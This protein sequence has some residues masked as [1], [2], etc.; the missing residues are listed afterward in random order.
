MAY[1]QNTCFLPNTARPYACGTIATPQINGQNVALRSAYVNIIMVVKSA[2]GQPKYIRVGNKSSPW[3]N[4]G[5]FIQNFKFGGENT[6]GGS[7]TIYDGTGNDLSTFLNALYEDSCTTN[8]NTIL[9][10]FGY[11]FQGINNQ[12]IMHGASSF[13][14]DSYKG[15]KLRDQPPPRLNKT[16]AQLL[17]GE[18]IPSIN[19]L[20][21]VVSKIDVKPN[22]GGWE[23]TV[24]LSTLID[25]KSMRK[26]LSRAYGSSSG[27]LSLKKAANQAIKDGCGGD[28]SAGAVYF[29]KQGPDG[30][31][32]DLEFSNAEGGEEGPKNVWDPNRLPCIGAIRNW[33]NSLRTKDG[34]GVTLYTDP[35]IDT[36]NLIVMEA[37]P[38]ICSPP[39]GAY[40][41]GK[42]SGPHKI[43]LVNAGDCSPVI[44][45]E[46]TVQ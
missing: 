8:T 42:K 37:S 15:W 11:I 32:N 9:V 17:G 40:C 34:L 21:F 23:Y 27:L 30:G 2:S 16:P 20:G 46:P 33:L 18:A 7:F 12:P 43:Y 25:K 28:P 29:A 5:A 44:S 13:I 39:N 19:W 35:V 26:L 1:P 45:F 3:Y 10:D 6:A 24:S 22:E 4:N 31:F 41:P 38:D 36:P 14:K